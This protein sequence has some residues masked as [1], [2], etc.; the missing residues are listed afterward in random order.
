MIRLYIKRM[1]LAALSAI[2]VSSA[3]S[4]IYPVYDGVIDIEEQQSVWQYLNVYSIYQNRLPQECGDNT[5]EQLFDIIDDKLRNSRYTG[6]YGGS[7]G[8]GAMAGVYGGAA[9]GCGNV[10]EI[11]DSTAY[12]HIPHF[13]DGALEDFNACRDG[14]TRFRNI[15]IDLRDNGGGYINA[16]DSII[17][18]FLPSGTAYIRTRHRVYD[19]KTLRGVTLE[20]SS[21]NHKA[22][23][24]LTNRKVSVLVNG[25]SASA[26]EIMA[27]AL[28]DRAN[29]RLLGVAPTYGK[30]IGQ[31]II[32]RTGRKTLSITFMQISGLTKRTG[33]YHEKGIEPDTIP[34]DL[35]LEAADSCMVG[36]LDDTGE[37]ASYLIDQSLYSAVKLMEPSAPAEKIYETAN[38]IWNGGAMQKKRAAEPVG[39]YMVT[40]PDPLG[41]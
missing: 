31:V 7:H 11:T 24:R 21:V 29:A 36:I 15:V 20:D 4:C 1:W 18:E 38:K 37:V 25:Y 41:L 6:Y 22:N 14:L 30:G 26:S 3:L 2:L 39:A 9:G 5:P 27:S 32:P 12:L 40:E 19:D 16:T 28:K 35:R 17:G 34:E 10:L 13:M 8:T 23:P 33:D